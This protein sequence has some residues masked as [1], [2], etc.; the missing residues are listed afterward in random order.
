MM[1]EQLELD[2]GIKEVFSQ[3]QVTKDHAIMIGK[4]VDEKI[5]EFT[6]LLFLKVVEMVKPYIEDDVPWISPNGIHFYLDQ[7][8]NDVILFYTDSDRTPIEADTKLKILVQ[9]TFLNDAGE[10][11]IKMMNQ[12][13][14]PEETLFDPALRAEYIR[15]CAKANIN[16][17]TKEREEVNSGTTSEDPGTT[18]SD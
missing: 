9:Y 7:V 14:A 17:E 15:I 1:C 4:L 6:D 5:P 10:E 3:K 16:G 11:V 2:L 8:E 12:G 13:Y 18:T